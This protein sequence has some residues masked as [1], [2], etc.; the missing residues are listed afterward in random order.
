MTRHP[1][2]NADGREN[3]E[4]AGEAIRKIMKTKD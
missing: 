2:G 3:K 1:P 4:L